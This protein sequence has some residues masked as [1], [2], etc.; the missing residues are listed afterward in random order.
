[1]HDEVMVPTI[2]QYVVFLSCSFVGP[3]L[4]PQH[5]ATDSLMGE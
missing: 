2:I 3:S 1:M 4:Y 5:S